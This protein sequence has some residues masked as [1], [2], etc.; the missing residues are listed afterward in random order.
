MFEKWGCFVKR[1]EKVDG[2]ALF[3]GFCE[4]GSC[5]KRLVRVRFSCQARFGDRGLLTEFRIGFN[6]NYLLLFLIIR[7]FIPIILSVIIWNNISIS[8]FLVIT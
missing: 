8:N 3:F 4:K 7:D 1:R 2:K 6:T 5:L